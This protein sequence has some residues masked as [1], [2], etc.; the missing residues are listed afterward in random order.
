MRLIVLLMLCICLLTA[1]DSKQNITGQVLA[2][3]PGTET[4][5][6][7]FVIL[8]NEGKEIS[9][10]MDN[11]TSVMS[12]QEGVAVEN[13]KSGKIVDVMITAE[14]NRSD[15][16]LITIDGKEMKAYTADVIRIIA[17]L[18]R[19]ALKLA[20]GKSFD[21]WKRSG[22]TVYQLNDGAELLEVRDPSGPNN[23]YVGGIESFDDL[24][25]EAQTNV[26]TYYNNR[27]LL[28]DV[29]IELERVYTDYMN[30]DKKSE[31]SPYLLSQDTAPA[32][33]NDKLIYFLTTVM[34][35]IDGNHGYEIRL[36]DAFDRETGRHISNWELFSCSE[37]EAKK[38]ILDRAGITDPVLRAEMEAAFK[39]EHIILFTDNL[40]LSFPEGT[41]PS[42]EHSYMLGLDYDE[43]LSDILN[44]WAIPEPIE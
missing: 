17:L 42:Q 16:S 11:E 10:L 5:T 33:S 38:A 15:S 25:E 4:E 21:I 7:Q 9:I 41:L 35:P 44:E 32:S 39:P 29:N 31:F 40:E 36:G 6:T 24:G 43:G 20:D 22:K 1:C 19:D 30:M 3:L 8:T 28:Y 34:I 14:Y 12:W 37:E 2:A 23:V 18:K 26:L 13:F 27:G